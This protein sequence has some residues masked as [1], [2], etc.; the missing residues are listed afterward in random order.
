MCRPQTSARSSRTLRLSAACSGV[1]LGTCRESRDLFVPD[2]YPFDL[3]LTAKRVRQPIQAVANNAINPL[4]A[5]RDDNETPN[6]LG[7]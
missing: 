1:R 3:V 6:G 7:T 4:G 2:M 5:S